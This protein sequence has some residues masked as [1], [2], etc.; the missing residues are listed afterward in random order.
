[1]RNKLAARRSLSRATASTHGPG[2]LQSLEPVLML[3][4]WGETR[5]GARAPVQ[6]VRAHMQ[7][8][9]DSIRAPMGSCQGNAL[10]RSRLYPS[11]SAEE[12]TRR[13]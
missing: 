7:M 1:M 4:R 10:E 6:A 9:A 11:P 8:Y 12:A 13:R 3:N 2:L 5:H